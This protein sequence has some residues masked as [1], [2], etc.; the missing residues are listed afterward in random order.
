MPEDENNSDVDIVFGV[1][2]YSLLKSLNYKPWFAIAEFVDNAIQ[3]F[4]ATKDQIYEEDPNFNGLQIKITVESD[5]LIV[6]D[7]A[8]GIAERDYRRA[9]KP[10]EVPPDRTGLSEFGIG[11]KSAAC[12]LANKWTVRTSALGESVIK[13]LEFN[14]PSIVE[15]NLTR[16]HPETEET[17]PSS[18]FTEVILSDLNKPPRGRTVTKIKSHLADI[19]R[20]FIERGDLEL[21]YNDELL[22]VEC[23]EI[24]IAPLYG[25]QNLNEQPKEWRKEFDI[26]LGSGQRAHGFAALRKKASTSHAGFSLFRRDRLIQGSGEDTYRPSQI[27][28]QTNSYEY[29][30]V[31]GDIHLEGFDVSHTK[32]GF[33]WGEGEDGEGEEEAFIGLLAS[34]L[35][36]EPM[37]LLSQAAG[38]RKRGYGET[39]EPDQLRATASQSV[40]RTAQL[41]QQSMTDV[42]GEQ[43]ELGPEQQ[44]PALDQLSNIAT[45]VSQVIDFEFRNNLWRINVELV[46]DPAVSDWLTLGQTSQVD[47]GSNTRRLLT[48]RMSI[49]HQFSQQFMGALGESLVPLHRLAAAFALAEITA[50]EA[51]VRKASTHRRVINELVRGPLS[52]P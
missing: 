27:F 17:D 5:R 10:A 16:L 30:R 52:Q 25:I 46:D 24:L 39:S 33:Q 48:V 45:T 31:F 42:V 18:H 2:S 11:M 29:Q 34:E 15:N 44:P 9:F 28:K 49:S 20:V 6:R 51:G 12:W 40:D 35:D 22:T 23:P 26:N 41:I 43:I 32:D 37:P 14:I 7:N 50:R 8:G 36:K 1:G 21:F 3:S 13:E 38:Y 47:A 4:L 19:Y